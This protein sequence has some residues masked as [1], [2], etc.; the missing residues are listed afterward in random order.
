MNISKY[1]LK[2]PRAPLK[3][4]TK[5]WSHTQQNIHFAEFQFCVWFT[6]T[7]ICDVIRLSET[8]PLSVTLKSSLCIIEMLFD[9]MTGS[10]TDK[11]PWKSSKVPR[12][13][14]NMIL[15]IRSLP[16]W[17][18]CKIFN[19][20]NERT[21]WDRGSAPAI[22]LIILFVKALTFANLACV[23]FT[24]LTWLQYMKCE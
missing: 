16:M 8:V 7:L 20:I 6:I 14:R 5:F 15:P 13:T 11:Y 9:N 18:N 21:V 4:Y 10:V 22:I 1:C 19:C 23:P 17:A 12:W 2:F 3:F 24:W